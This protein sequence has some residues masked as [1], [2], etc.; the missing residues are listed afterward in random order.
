MRGP[1]QR[2]SS[3]AC[4]RRWWP[5]TTAPIATPQTKLRISTEL[6]TSLST[7]TTTTSTGRRLSNSGSSRKPLRPERFPM[8]CFGRF[9]TTPQT[10]SST[11]WSERTEPTLSKRTP[12]AMASPII[13][14]GG[15]C[16]ILDSTPRRRRSTCILRLR[17]PRPSRSRATSWQQSNSC[18][19]PSQ[20]AVRSGSIPISFVRTAQ[21]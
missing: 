3:A 15:R 6:L 11:G 4:P 10:G 13:W 20:P 1:E 16:R 14:S 2:R 8:M 19:L 18:L 7:G 5:M 9:R 12:A 17:R 21:S